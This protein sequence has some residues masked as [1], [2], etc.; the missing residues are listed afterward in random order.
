MIKVNVD[1]SQVFEIRE[2]QQRIQAYAEEY[3]AILA[4]AA[5]GKMLEL[6]EQRLHSRRELFIENLF[7]NQVEPGKWAVVLGKKAEWIEDGTTSRNMIEDLLSWK[8]GKRVKT[9]KDGV[10]SR[11]IPFNHT[12][13]GLQSPAQRALSSAVKEALRER[14][15]DTPTGGKR[16]KK[17]GSFNITDKPISTATLRIGAGPVGQVAQGKASG[18]P[19]LKGV[20]AAQKFK[21]KTGKVSV[22]ALTFRTVSDRS[23]PGSWDHPGNEPTNI[24]SDAAS[25]SEKEAEKYVMEMMDKVSKEKG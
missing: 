19:I 20:V 25:W 23:R 1:L 16:S 21:A 17:L 7:L 5:Y 10:R 8:S 11:V 15:I 2:Y 18:I 9:S 24:M 22:Q 6:A 3:S 4:K 13:G 12:K 14:G